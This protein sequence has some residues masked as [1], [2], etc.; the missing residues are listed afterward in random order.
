MNAKWG[1]QDSF[2]DLEE[3]VSSSRRPTSLGGSGWEEGTCTITHLCSDAHW[4][5]GGGAEE[6][7]PPMLLGWL[8]VLQPASRSA[9]GTWTN[10]GG[11][12]HFCSC[13]LLSD[14]GGLRAEPLAVFCFCPNVS[15]SQDFLRAAYTKSHSFSFS[16]FSLTISLL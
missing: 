7:A 12:G 6:S 13:P 9:R 1:S 11:Q 5:K 8:Q 2:Q 4:H 3:T 10:L 14:S 15:S 16:H